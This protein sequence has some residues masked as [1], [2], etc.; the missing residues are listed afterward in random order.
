M[1][2][3]SRRNRDPHPS[4]RGNREELLRQ[5][6]ILVEGI[7]DEKSAEVVIAQ[8]LY[9]QHED[10]GRPIW[11]RIDSEGGSVAAGMAIAD[12]IKELSLA[13][14]TTSQLQAGGIATII[15]AS[16]RK[17]FRSASRSAEIVITPIT[18]SSGHAVAESELDRICGLLATHL[19]EQSGQPWERT[20][21]D[22]SVGCS[23]T[24]QAAQEYGLIDSVVE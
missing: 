20:F 5:R 11:L 18:S 7:I 21:R 22:L 1:W 16:G 10:P 13:V 2:F 12:T 6:T 9:L 23:L 4:E 17:G 19:S 15:L 14:Q 3:F 8:M 24:A